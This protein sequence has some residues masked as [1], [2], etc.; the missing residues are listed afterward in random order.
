MTSHL[1]KVI[2]F[3]HNKFMLDLASESNLS[4]HVGITEQESFEMKYDHVVDSDG[5][6]A[7]PSHLAGFMLLHLTLAI[8]ANASPIIQ[9]QDN[10]RSAIDGIR[11]QLCEKVLENFIKRSIDCKKS[12]SRY[13]AVKCY[14]FSKN[15]EFFSFID[16][17]MLLSKNVVAFST[18]AVIE[19]P[20]KRLPRKG[21]ILQ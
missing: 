2:T 3:S 17:S 18:L 19:R 8:Y 13:L 7:S 5:V 21:T 15:H 20:Y 4:E 14:H 10:I 11:S 1:P 6:Q 9:A 12:P 16:Q